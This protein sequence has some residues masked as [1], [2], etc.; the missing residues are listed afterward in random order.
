MEKVINVMWLCSKPTNEYLEKL[1]K[2]NIH[3]GGWIDSILSVIKKSK[4]IHIDYVFFVNDKNNY[5]EIKT[6]DVNYYPVRNYDEANKILKQNHMLHVFGTENKKINQFVLKND[7]NNIV[8]WLQ[9]LLSEYNYYYYGINEVIKKSKISNALI[10]K[11]IIFINYRLYRLRSKGEINVLKKVKYVIGRTDWD[12]KISLSI[13]PNLTY[14]YCQEVLRECFYNKKLWK[15]KILKPHSIYISQANYPIKGFHN[16]IRPLSKVKE[17][18]PDLT[19]RIS[20]ENI[21]NS[22]NKLTNLG[23]NYAGLIKKLLKKYDLLDSVQFLG[24]INSE[25]VKKELLNNNIFLLCSNIENSPNSFGEALMTG[26]PIVSVDVGGIGSLADNK[27]VHYYSDEES[28]IKQIESIFDHKIPSTKVLKQ[29]NKAT[30]NYNKK[31]ILKD[32][33]NIYK[34][35]LKEKYE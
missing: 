7:N 29:R 15:N 19:I 26:T 12:K 21:L 35:I 27:I 25:K 28:L 20:G 6:N 17:K 13:N 31:Q 8:V 32:L 11:F 16:V 18:Y 30:H 34:S 24:T 4:K 3:Y 33:E 23:I 9:G 2:T 1:N 10:T 22:N 5:K 14:F